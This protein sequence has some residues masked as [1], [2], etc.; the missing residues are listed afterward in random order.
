[1]G[2]VSR[3]IPTG[4]I[5]DMRK[6]LSES[7]NFRAQLNFTRTWN[8]HSLNAL[9]GYEM[10][11]V[12]TEGA[13]ARYYG[14]D[15][16]LA[17][18]QRVDYVGFYEQYYFPGFRT[19]IPN[20]EGLSSTTDR[21]LSWYANAGYTFRKRYSLSASARRDQSN[22]FG[23]RAN[24]RGVPLWSAGAGWQISGERFYNSGLV[25]YLKLRA[26]YGYNGNINKRLSAFTTAY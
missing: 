17:T 20:N 25:P 4:G 26:T 2:L 10:R 8:D 21:Y 3:P 19:Q 24:Q 16:A 1:Q 12:A 9:A 5:L 23:V 6:V 15:D 18:S 14:Y 11:E 7:Y 13:N 22:L